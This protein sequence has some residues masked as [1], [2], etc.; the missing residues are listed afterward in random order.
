MVAAADRAAA[1]AGPSGA[2][3]STVTTGAAEGGMEMSGGATSPTGDEVDM[4][5]PTPAGG[6]G[7]AGRQEEAFCTEA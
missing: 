5:A 2:G 1:G 3:P 6:K 4:G 7:A